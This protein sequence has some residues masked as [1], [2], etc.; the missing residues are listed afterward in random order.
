MTEPAKPYKITFS[1]RTAYLYA[2]LEGD[3]ISEE[4]ISGYITEVVEKSNETGLHK[5]LLYRD[6]PAVLTDGEVFRTVNDSL[7]ALTG[8]KVAL[9]NPHAAIQTI[10]EFGMTVG[11]NR[12]GNYQSFTN[13]AEA[14]AWLLK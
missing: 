9:V 2:H 4:I 3:T 5:I 11:Q 8:K 7:R 12:G 6:I 1:E 14:E 13:V 10:V